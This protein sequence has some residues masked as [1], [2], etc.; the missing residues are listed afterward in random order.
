MSDATRQILE[1]LKPEFEKRTQPY[2][3]RESALLACLHAVQDAYGFVT[4]DAEAAV[5]EFLEVGRNRVHEAV[6]FYTLYRTKPYGKHHFA[7]C[8]TLSCDLC[9]TPE[10]LAAIRKKCGG[11]PEKTVTPDGLFSYETVECLG[12]CDKAPALQVNQDAFKGPM[13]AEGVTQLMNELEA[14][15]KANGHG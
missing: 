3:H 15:A 5:A 4:P 8:R 13:T 12:C 2:S 11:I 7:L 10:V 6:T 14:K 9:G 1:K